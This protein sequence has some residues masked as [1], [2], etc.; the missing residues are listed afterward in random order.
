MTGQAQDA[1]I[2]DEA[3]QWLARWY[4]SDFGEKERAALAQWRRQSPRHE[5]VWQRATQLTR[6]LRDVPPTV[7]MQVLDRPRTRR[8]TLRA[9][10]LALTTPAIGWLAYQHTPWR[11]WTADVR[12]EAGSTRRVVLADQSELQLNTSSAVSVNFDGVS[13]RIQ[14][15]AGEIF[16]QTARSPGYSSQPFIVQ[17]ED[18]SMQALGTTFM[19]RKYPRSTNVSVFEGAVRVVPAH[20]S[21]QVVVRA[22]EQLR[23]DASHIES[24]APLSPYAEAWTRGVLYAENMRLADFLDEIGRYRDG[25]VTYD[26]DVADMRV[27]GTYQLNDTDQILA[28]LTEALAVRQVRATRYWV[29]VTRA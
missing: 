22:G 11:A 19:V 15:Y 24:V 29:R 26:D 17:T 16:I 8:Q 27:S 14:Q 3:A 2:L 25:I 18:G 10:M 5:E 6:Q 1:R 23:F 28:L 9:L 4:A 13:R 12:T 20:A 7:G 21:E